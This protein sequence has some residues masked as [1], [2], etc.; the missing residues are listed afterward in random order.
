MR[1]NEATAILLVF[2]AI[3]QLARA[4]KEQST[5]KILDFI[6]YEKLSK[7]TVN[8]KRDKLENWGALTREYKHQ[9]KSNIYSHFRPE[10]IPAFVYQSQISPTTK[11]NWKHKYGEDGQFAKYVDGDVLIDAEKLASL[12]PESLINQVINDAKSIFSP[13]EP[14]MS[15][16]EARAK[17]IDILKNEKIDF[18]D[19]FLKDFHRWLCS[20]VENFYADT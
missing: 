5:N 1:I 3:F 4:G 20:E 17:F 7:T 19:G 13:D 16:E 15:S 14:R 11:S 18:A 9:G 12:L 10:R 8:D 6:N 2:Y